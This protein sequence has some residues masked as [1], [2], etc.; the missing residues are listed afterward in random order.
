MSPWR[1]QCLKISVNRKREKFSKNF[2]KIKVQSNVDSIECIPIESVS[3]IANVR[4]WRQKL[5]R[6][7]RADTLR[8]R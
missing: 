6:Y 2:S 1:N 8:E 3:R 4:P 5:A 7:S